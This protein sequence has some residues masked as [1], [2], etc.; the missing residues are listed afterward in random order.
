MKKKKSLT[1]S[2]CLPLSSSWMVRQSE[3]NMKN[4]SQM[5]TQLME[6]Q[7]QVDSGMPPGEIKGKIKQLMEKLV[8]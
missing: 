8:Q 3:E 2:G 5:T 4:R 6:L 7:Q 1:C